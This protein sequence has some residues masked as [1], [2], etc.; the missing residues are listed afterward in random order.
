MPSVKD[1]LVAARRLIEKP[2]N[3][4][5]DD[6]AKDANGE[7]TCTG[8]PSTVSRCALGDQQSIASFNDSHNH[9]QVLALFDKAIEKCSP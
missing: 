2:E 1:Y 7:G 4:T 9:A 5:Q 8:D 6:Y 3:W